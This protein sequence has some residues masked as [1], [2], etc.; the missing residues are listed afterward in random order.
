MP[1]ICFSSSSFQKN[2]RIS[3][4]TNYPIDELDFEQVL[5]LALTH[6]LSPFTNYVKILLIMFPLNYIMFC[7][8]FSHIYFNF[9]LI[10][11]DFEVY[12]LL[13]ES[14]I[15]WFSW[16][17]LYCPCVRSALTGPIVR[18]ETLVVCSIFIHT[19]I[20]GCLSNPENAI[21][22]YRILVSRRKCLRGRLGI[23]KVNY[24]VLAVYVG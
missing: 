8:L 13:I 20:V 24:V 10:Y 14:L 15:E 17:G 16:R 9:L 5:N 11:T 23:G 3:R 2:I 21:E 4:E 7:L 12:F 18:L 22:S 19:K 6:L 1:L